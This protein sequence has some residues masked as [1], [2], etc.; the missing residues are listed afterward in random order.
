MSATTPLG[1]RLVARGRARRRTRLT[2]TLVVL[3]LA[4]LLGVGSW[5]LLATSVFGVRQVLVTGTSRLDP[6]TVRETARIP[7]GAPLATLDTGIVVTRL[8]ALPVVRSVSVRRRWPAS[9]AITVR[10]RRPAAAAPAGAGFVLLDRA[11]VAFDRVATPPRGLP[12]LSAALAA[13]TPALRAALRVLR[14][15]PPAVA[16]QV[17]Q[18]SADS[19]DA[20]RLQLGGG[21]TVVWGSSGRAAR[22][23]AV[24]AVLLTRRARVYDVS[25]PDAPT[26]RR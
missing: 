14:A 9:V 21:R 24:L 25:A 5:L 23:A 3:G 1:P 17:R 20:V 10:E 15:L 4:S 11:G 8:R 19:P 22:K 18:V 2:V 12:V 13:R 16:R 6:Q 7:A 26:T